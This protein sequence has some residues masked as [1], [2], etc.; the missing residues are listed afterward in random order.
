MLDA[1]HQAADNPW[2]GV[3]FRTSKTPLRFRD[4]QPYLPSGERL[5]SADED[6]RG[7][8]YRLRRRE[9][10]ETDFRYPQLTYTVSESDLLPPL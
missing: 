6:Q 10:T 7:E 5:I 1:P 4:R 9:N 2:L 8:F 3:T